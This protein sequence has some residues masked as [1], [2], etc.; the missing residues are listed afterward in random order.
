MTKNGSTQNK[1]QQKRVIAHFVRNCSLNNIS[2]VYQNRRS[3]TVPNLHKF[4]MAAISIQFACNMG[5][6][7][8]KNW[9]IVYLPMFSG[10]VNIMK[11]I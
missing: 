4:K 10:S 9:I 1:L 8:F 7:I 2:K 11:V 5:P 3:G 6:E